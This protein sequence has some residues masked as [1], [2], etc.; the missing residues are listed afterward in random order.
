MTSPTADNA[1]D[2]GHLTTAPARSFEPNDFGLWSMAGNVWEWCADWFSP[3]YYKHSP[4]D[5]PEGPRYG[6]EARVM[7]G[8]SW[9]CHSS[10][11]NR[12]RVAARSSNTPDSSRATSAPPRHLTRRS[13]SALSEQLAS[14]LGVVSSGRGAS[15]VVAGALGV[16]GPVHETFGQQR[17]QLRS[18]VG[19][20]LPERGNE[21]GGRCRSALPQRR[22]QRIVV[23]LLG[24]APR[25]IGRAADRVG[26]L[27][28]RIEP[29]RRAETPQHGVRVNG[30][31]R[32]DGDRGQ[33]LT[34]RE[35]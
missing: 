25:P 28:Q 24:E 11:C 14:G 3:Y 18:Y 22:Q 8:G 9:L 27:G 31:V 10:Y 30:F 5:N 17:A 7:R 20:R 13:P 15:G 6:Q 16:A 1:L 21:L 26:Q 12:Y 2:D 34:R 35:Q 19:G 23:A 32:L 29:G 33:I 4:A